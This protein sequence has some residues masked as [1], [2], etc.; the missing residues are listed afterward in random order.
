MGHSRKPV[1]MV[2]VMVVAGLVAVALVVGVLLGGGA[3]VIDR[4][5]R[6][7]RLRD[8]T[9]HVYEVLEKS[10][11]EYEQERARNR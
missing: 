1:V 9:R 5:V 10:D 11:R 7:Q 8:G 2:P 4:Q 3:S 6:D